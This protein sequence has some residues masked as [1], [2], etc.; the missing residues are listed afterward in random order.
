MPLTQEQIDALLKADLLKAATP[1]SGGGK[2]QPANVRL[3]PRP[4]QFGPLRLVDVAG[5]CVARGCNSTTHIKIEGRGYLCFNHSLYELNKQLLLIDRGSNWLDSCNCK[6]GQYSNGHTH[7]VD[8][9]LYT[10]A[11]ETLESVI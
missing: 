8:C 5:R 3:L 1:P 10:L 4:Q 9:D 7:T 6:A 2:G 11:K